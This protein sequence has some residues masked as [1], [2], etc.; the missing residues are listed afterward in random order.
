MVGPFLMLSSTHHQMDNTTVHLPVHLSMGQLVFFILGPLQV[1]LC[2][3]L[4]HEPLWDT[5]LHFSRLKTNTW[6]RNSCH[7]TAALFF[8]MAI[9]SDTQEEVSAP[10]PPLSCQHAIH[11]LVNHIYSDRHLVVPHCGLSLHFPKV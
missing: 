9:A 10:A 1:N 11:S 5:Y 8:K 2:W 4:R 3:R 7:E 6:E